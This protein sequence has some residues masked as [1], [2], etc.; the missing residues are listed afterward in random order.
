M[1]RPGTR[2]VHDRASFLVV[3]SITLLV[4]GLSLFSSN[5]TVETF[6][7]PLFF[8]ALVL[9]FVGLGQAE[10]DLGSE[11]YRLLVAG[12]SVLS[13]GSVAGVLLRRQQGPVADALA[14]NLDQGPGFLLG[15]ALIAYG[16]VLWVPEVVAS[17]RLLRENL[18]RIQDQSREQGQALERARDL[19][20]RREVLANL[21][22]LAAGLAHELKNP[23]AIV[24]SAL[25][26]LEEPDLDEDERRHCQTVLDRAIRKANRNITGLLE[27]GREHPYRPGLHPA[28]ELLHKASDLAHVDARRQRVGIELAGADAASRFWG[29]PDLLLQ[30]LIN[31]LRN[32]VQAGPHLGPIRLSF[33]QHDAATGACRIAV[34]DLG[35]GIPEGVLDKLGTPFFTTKE[36]GTGL[37]L[38]MCGR[39]LDRHGGSFGLRPREPVGAIAALVL[40]GRSAA[41]EVLAQGPAVAGAAGAEVGHG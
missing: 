35:A 21:G 8:V 6:L 15:L 39:I 13:I 24:E 16:I 37:G 2:T 17:Q 34:E 19:M 10:P 7:R 22:E 25:R 38:S 27:L 4:I 1:A 9:Y 41:E 31:L 23:L 33:E 20:E 32:S 12:F 29:D 26:T 14:F 3:V 5:P 40:P 11:G 28:L 36:D 18:S 30:V